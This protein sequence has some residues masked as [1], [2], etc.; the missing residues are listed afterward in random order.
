[1]SNSN[2][3]FDFLRWSRVVSSG[4]WSDIGS[5]VLIDS[6]FLSEMKRNVIFTMRAEVT[7]ASCQYL[8]LTNFSLNIFYI[9]YMIT[10]SVK[11]VKDVHKV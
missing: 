8:Q 9:K 7:Q 11:S 3:S 10:S 5:V 6:A 4:R 2:L 1:M